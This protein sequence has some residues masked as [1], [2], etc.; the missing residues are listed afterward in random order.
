MALFDQIVAGLEGTGQLASAILPYTESGQQ[1]DYLKDLTGELSTQA[2]QLGQQAAQ[3]SAFTPFTVKTATGAQ[4]DVGAGGGFTQNLSNVEQALQRGMFGQ[5]Q[6]LVGEGT[7]S[8]ADIFSQLQAAQAGEAER[9]RLGLEQRLAAQGRLGVGTAMYGGTPEQLALEKALQERT[10]ANWLQA[11]QLAPTIAGQQL[12]NV[13]TALQNAYVPQSQNLAALQIASP[14]SQ[15]AQAG[16]QGQS[17]A[18]Y[19]SG[20]TGLETQAAGAG[21]VAGLEGQ[22]VRALADSLSGLFQSETEY[23]PVSKT[24]KVGESV[25]SKILGL[26]GEEDNGN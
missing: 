14:F 8:A 19:K 23:D 3:A 9:A 4:A 24:F 21:A 13:G 7:A 11:Q 18:L 6:G 22:R 16:R 15:I 5:A 26:F 10:A 12:S 17:E 1:I 20:I 2:S 25:L